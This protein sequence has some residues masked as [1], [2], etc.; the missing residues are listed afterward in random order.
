MFVSVETDYDHTW[1]NVYVLDVGLTASLRHILHVCLT[2]W[3]IQ[4][5]TCKQRKKEN[6]N[7]CFH[8]LVLE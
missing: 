5:C 2:S 7:E 6:A 8:P 1:H 4:Y 3:K